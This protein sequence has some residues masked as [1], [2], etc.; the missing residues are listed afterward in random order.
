[1]KPT[2]FSTLRPIA[3]DAM[4][5]A[6][7]ALIAATVYL[8]IVQPISAHA[9]A[10]AAEANEA[11]ALERQANDQHAE[12]ARLQ[13]RTSTLTEQAERTLQLTSVNRL[14]DRLKALADLADSISH[15]D[16]QANP[17]FVGPPTPKWLT[18][19]TA[20]KIVQIVPGTP[21]R[22]NKFVTVPIRLAG[23]ATYASATL[24]LA[25]LHK[26]FPD[27]AVARLS[28]AVDDTVQRDDGQPA[29]RGAGASESNG[30]PS[31]RLAPASKVS[32]DLVWCA[33]PEDSA[34]SAGEAPK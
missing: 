1:M 20:L 32:V 25:E 12:L 6:A 33:A 11:D 30:A 27:T 2:F 21:T 34:G 15:S 7:L 16:E 3:V 26:Q 9:N 8:A 18:D 24:F 13:K 17:A 4:G 19:A 14:N 23:T 29:E 22:T 31:R 10:L 5:A 28:I